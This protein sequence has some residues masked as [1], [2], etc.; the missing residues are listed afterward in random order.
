M[1]RIQSSRT[2]LSTL[3]LFF[4]IL[5]GCREGEERAQAN[6]TESQPAKVTIVKVQ[7]EEIGNQVEIMGTIQAA[8][9]AVIA[10]RING[11]IIALPV[12]LGSRVK[13]GERLIQISAGEISAKLLQ[14]TAQLNQAERNLNREQKLLKK[15]AATPEGV[16]TQEDAYKIA[17]ASHKEARTI[18]SY[19]NI[20]APFDGIITRKMANIGDLATPGKPLLHLENESNHQ[21][22]TDIPEA[23]VIKMRLGD[24]VTVSVPAAETTRIGTVAEIAPAADP[25]S[26]TATV[27]IHLPVISNLRSGQF[28]RVFLTE[29]LQ[30]AIMVPIEA[31]LPFGQMERVFLVENDRARLRLVRTGRR[32]NGK[33]EILSGLTPGDTIISHGNKNLQDGQK[34]IINHN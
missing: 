8:E 6:F 7:E 3:L 25:L 12:T 24:T 27:K 19:T 31:V 18:L 1:Q 14:A 9:R 22:L 34:V 15:D 32:E 13:A 2:L 30:K 21:V 28:A 17:Q 29:S 33:T 4:L 10:A 23:M 5:P 11:H 16:K 26:R 20:T